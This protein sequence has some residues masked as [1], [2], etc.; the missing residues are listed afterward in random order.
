MRRHPN[1]IYS[2]IWRLAPNDK[3]PKSNILAIKQFFESD[4]VAAQQYAEY[5]KRFSTLKG[6]ETIYKRALDD[7]EISKKNIET[8]NRYL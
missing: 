6:F 5:V 7:I 1:K 3:L 4:L 2:G 8:I